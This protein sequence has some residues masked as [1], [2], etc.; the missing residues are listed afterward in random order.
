[1]DFGTEI[2]FWYFGNLERSIHFVA[3]LVCFD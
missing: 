2:S 1:M 3:R